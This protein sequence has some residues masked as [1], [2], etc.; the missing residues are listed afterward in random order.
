MFLLGLG[1]IWE[2]GVSNWCL[3]GI[4]LS[5]MDIKRNF[6]L[7]S[8]CS[9][10]VGGPADYYIHAKDE[11]DLIE[12][13]KR[14]KELRVPVFFLG[15]GT[16]IFF[17]DEGFRGVIIRFFSSK[18]SFTIGDGV[19]LLK[20]NEKAGTLVRVLGDMGIGGL[21]FLA[22][23]PGS[24]GGAVACNAGTKTGCIDDVFIRGRILD[25]Q[26]NRIFETDKIFFD[27]SYRDSRLKRENRYVLIEC[28][29]RIKVMERS[30]I[31]KIIEEDL[32]QRRLSQPIKTKTA[33]SFFKNPPGRKAW[34]LIRECGLAGFGIGGAYISK[35]HSNFIVNRGGATAKD[36]LRLARF[37]AKIVLDKTG[38]KLEPEVVFVGQKGM[39]KNWLW[40]E[41]NNFLET[42]RF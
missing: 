8:I 17:C 22:N 36:I 30:E 5:E 23:I 32:T 10:S 19:V 1:N 16:N 20:G 11:R 21:E 3:F 35:K 27:F 12:A 29:L 28:L 15:L 7:S 24:I 41:D 26:K 18:K 6:R 4:F 33:G 39:K 38:I 40:E 34:E 14:A 42:T 25:I 9:F 37:T 2:N 31:L 13:I